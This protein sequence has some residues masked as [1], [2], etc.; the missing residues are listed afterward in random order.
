MEENEQDFIK[1]QNCSVV[2]AIID[3]RCSNCG[4]KICTICGC[5]DSAAC[6]GG[7]CWTREGVCSQC[8]AETAEWF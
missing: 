5:T 2:A 8:D 7:C 1:C 4:E 6:P 3:G